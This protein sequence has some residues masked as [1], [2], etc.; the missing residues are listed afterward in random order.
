MKNVMNI[1]AALGIVGATAT[2]I[3]VVSIYDSI[4]TST[5]LWMI[6]GIYLLIWALAIA[7]FLIICF[8]IKRHM[9]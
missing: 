1:G 8:I 6:I 3:Y 5:P 9:K 7:V 2:V 4:L